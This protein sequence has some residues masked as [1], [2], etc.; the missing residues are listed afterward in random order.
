[1][2]GCFLAHELFLWVSRGH[3]I[4]VLTIFPLKKKNHSGLEMWLTGRGLIQYVQCPGTAM[5]ERKDVHLFIH[6][7][8]NRS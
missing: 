8:L 5:K 4:P 2:L 3:E 6:N 1:V 7:L